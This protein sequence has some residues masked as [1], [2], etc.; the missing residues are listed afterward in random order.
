MFGRHL[1]GAWSILSIHAQLAGEIGGI[2]LDHKSIHPVWEC[3]PRRDGYPIAA[4]TPLPQG[5]S[6]AGVMIRAAASF[7]ALRVTGSIPWPTT[8]SAA[9]TL[10]TLD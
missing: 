9:G 5:E 2:G 7:F 8:L 10:Q 4:R 6:P 3:R 1:A